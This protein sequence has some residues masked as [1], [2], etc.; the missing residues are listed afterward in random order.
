MDSKS[1]SLGKTSLKKISVT[2]SSIVN[3]QHLTSLR[4]YFP[5][6]LWKL[7]TITNLWLDILPFLSHSLLKFCN[8]R[9]SYNGCETQILFFFCSVAPPSAE[10]K[11][12]I[13]VKQPKHFAK[14]TNRK[15]NCRKNSSTY[16]LKVFYMQIRDRVLVITISPS[17]SAALTSNKCPFNQTAERIHRMGKK[18]KPFLP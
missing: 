7:L 3:F 14:W 16:T 13:F 4:K 10:S 18:L 1:S 15:D 12:W 5:D 6:W 11:H 2:Q 9:Y 8:F 17:G